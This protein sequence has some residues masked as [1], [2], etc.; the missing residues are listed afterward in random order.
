[1]TCLKCESAALAPHAE[2]LPYGSAALNGVHV[3]QLVLQGDRVTRSA[4]QY[5]FDYFFEVPLS[6]A[7]PIWLASAAL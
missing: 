4:L 6:A 2:V 7:R 5:L 3:G 1:M